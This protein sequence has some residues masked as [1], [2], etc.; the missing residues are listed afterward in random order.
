MRKI[1]EGVTAKGRYQLCVAAADGELVVF[2]SSRF[3]NDAQ[4][5]YSPIEGEALM[6]YWACCKTDYFIYS[7]DKLYIGL[8][9]KPQLAFFRKVDPK[10]LE[11]IVNKRLRKYVSQ[12]NAIWFTLFHISGTKISYGAGGLNFIVVELVMIKEKV[13]NVQGSQTE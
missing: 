13:L 9:H 11:H 1:H 12:I 2:M 4:S 10:P 3:N 6:G 5:R 7:C 8:D